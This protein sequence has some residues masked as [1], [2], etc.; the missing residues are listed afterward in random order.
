[1]LENFLLLHPSEFGHPGFGK[2]CLLNILKFSTEIRLC[3]EFNLSN[4]ELVSL[5]PYLNMAI[6][7]ETLEII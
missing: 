5:F 6:K 3:W 7:K 2:W 4:I 1:M